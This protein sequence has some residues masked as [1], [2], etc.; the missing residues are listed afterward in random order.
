MNNQ[1]QFCSGNPGKFFPLFSPYS[2]LAELIFCQA[3]WNLVHSDRISTKH[4]SRPAGLVLLS[5]YL[6]PV[7]NLPSHPLQNGTWHDIEVDYFHSNFSLDISGMHLM[8]V[9]VTP[10][11]WF[12]PETLPAFQDKLNGLTRESLLDSIVTGIIGTN[13][14]LQWFPLSLLQFF[15]T[16][17]FNLFPFLLFTF[18]PCFFSSSSSRF[19]S[20]WWHQGLL[21]HQVGL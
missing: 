1:I 5:P 7:N 9:N 11:A 2:R 14:P 18:F 13:L 17:L 15:L 6:L 20:H 8:R 3:I 4:S 21:R 10:G 19:Q 16:K 12:I